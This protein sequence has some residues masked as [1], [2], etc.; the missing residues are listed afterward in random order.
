MMFCRI[1]RPTDPGRQARA[2][3][4]HR[5]RGQHVP[6]AGR[7]GGP[8][9]FGDRITVGAQGGVGLVGG[10]R[11]REVVHAV[12]QGAVHRQPSVGEHPQH[13]RVLAQRLGGEGPDP[14]AAAQRDQVLQQQHGG[15]PVM[16]V[17]G[18]RDGDLGGPGAD[19]G[20][21]V[22]AAAAHLAV[23]HGEQRGVVRGGLAAYPQCLPLGRG[24]VDAEEA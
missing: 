2:D 22:G 8:F 16:Q 11:E 1:A 20:D 21:L 9:P 6:Q 10:Q 5:G 18:D 23:Q 4:R 14:P 24:R 12:R 19:A 15:T 7:V 13:G 3:H 17:I